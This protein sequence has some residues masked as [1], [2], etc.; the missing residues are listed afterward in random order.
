MSPRLAFHPAVMTWCWMATCDNRLLRASS[1]RLRR[2]RSSLNL[3]DNTTHSAQIGHAGERHVPAYRGHAL[4]EVNVTG[5]PQASGPCRCS[6]T[7]ESLWRNSLSP[8]FQ[9][10]TVCFAGTSRRMQRCTLRGDLRRRHPGSYISVGHALPWPIATGLCNYDTAVPAPL[11]RPHTFRGTLGLQRHP[12]HR[13]RAQA[14]AL[15]PAL[16]WATVA[17][18]SAVCSEPLPMRE[19]RQSSRL[20][21]GNQYPLSHVKLPPSRHKSHPWT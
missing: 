1:A 9:L 14:W 16:G 8:P 17:L 6:D 13:R 3:A 10:R 15:T 11:L 2:P 12:I 21:L 20:E 19:S 4:V 5:L 7:T 18:E